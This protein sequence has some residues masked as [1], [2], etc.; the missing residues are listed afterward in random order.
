MNRDNILRER[1]LAQRVRELKDSLDLAQARIDELE[2]ALG[3][4]DDITPLRALGLT[5]SEARFVNLLYRNGFV[6]KAMAKK[7]VYVDEPD[8]AFEV[9][10]KIID[11]I[12]CRSRQKLASFGVAI[13]GRVGRGNYGHVMLPADQARLRDLLAARAD[14]PGGQN[15]YAAAAQSRPRASNGVFRAAAE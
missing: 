15:R 8:K 12:A 6:T 5:P 7:A 1:Y 11:V 9:Q 14:E 13:N 2:K 4:G 10:D 3:M